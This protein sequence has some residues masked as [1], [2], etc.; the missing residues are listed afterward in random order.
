[1]LLNH[2]QLDTLHILMPMNVDD[3]VL[4]PTYTTADDEGFNDSRVM[5]CRTVNSVLYILQ[6][7]NTFLLVTSEWS[8]WSGRFSS[9]REPVCL[10]PPLSPSICSLNPTHHCCFLAG[11]SIHG[12]KHVSNKSWCVFL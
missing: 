12:S 7:S 2:R 3:A 9:G 6:R 11:G 8:H 4:A 10:K 5:Y 1:M